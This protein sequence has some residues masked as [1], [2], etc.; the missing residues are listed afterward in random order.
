V[1]EFL[2]VYTYYNPTAFKLRTNEEQCQL[3]DRYRELTT[4]TA[5]KNFVKEHATR[6]TQLS[7]LPYFD[8]VEQ[9]VIDPMHNL[10]LGM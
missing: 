3:G 1:I 8:L 9:I 4:P 10:F 6:F 7:R 5:R 2:L